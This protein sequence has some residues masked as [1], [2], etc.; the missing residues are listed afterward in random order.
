MRPLRSVEKAQPVVAVPWADARTRMYGPKQFIMSILYRL[1]TPGV[2]RMRQQSVDK[3]SP[4]STSVLGIHHIGMAVRSLSSAVEFYENTSLERLSLP[5]ISGAQLLPPTRTAV[6]KAP[7]GHI[8]LME[9]PEHPTGSADTAPIP[10]EGPGATH[11]C[12]QSPA[13]LS[14]YR[15]LEQAAASPVSR[16]THLLT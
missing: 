1:H 6:L 12:F 7:N 11:A 15:K 2:S 10:V 16:E 3:Q 13:H 9:F 14:L 4:P 8:E 5:S